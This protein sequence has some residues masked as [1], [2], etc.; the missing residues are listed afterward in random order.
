MNLVLIFELRNT[1]LWAYTF[2]L[3]IFFVIQKMIKKFK[4][5]LKF[6]YIS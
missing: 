2:I 3:L 4:N 1:E 5:S 6:A